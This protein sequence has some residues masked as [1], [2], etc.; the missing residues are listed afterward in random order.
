V[1][2]RTTPATAVVNPDTGPRSAPNALA[3]SLAG[4][5]P[6][7]GG[8]F[9]GRSSGGRG[10]GRFGRGGGRAGFGRGGGRAGFGCGGGRGGYGCGGGCSGFGRGGGRGGG[11]ES[12]SNITSRRPPGRSGPFPPPRDGDS[13]IKMSDG[14]KYY[15]CQKCKR[16][17][18]SHSTDTHKSKDELSQTTRSAHAG[19][20]KVSFDL[21]PAAYK[22]I[23]RT[24][25]APSTVPK[26]SMNMSTIGLFSLM[27]MLMNWVMLNWRFVTLT[28]M[29]TS[30]F[31]WDTIQSNLLIV[32]LSILS[33]VISGVT[34]YMISNRVVPVELLA[35]RPT[36]SISCS[37][38]PLLL[39]WLSLVSRL[40]VDK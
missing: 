10:S 4:R 36:P 12:Y 28:M 30:V 29:H 23:V 14:K 27:S 26:S 21:H 2:S 7:R 9:Q 32:A 11:R 6:G 39:I 18:L 19:M 34:T 31:L 24:T 40:F 35:W 20:A 5:D 37:R 15:F 17:N 25:P 3:S 8:R 22:A 33:F 13:K 16:W 38:Q 1:T